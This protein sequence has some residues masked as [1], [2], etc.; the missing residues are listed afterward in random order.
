MSREVP[1][2]FNEGVALMVDYR[3]PGNGLDN[4]YQ[5][6]L[7]KWQQSSLEGQ[8]AVSLQELESVESFYRGDAFWINLAYLRSGLE[9]SGWLEK[10]KQPGL[11]QFTQALQHEISFEE[12]WRMTN[13]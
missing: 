9:V 5:N 10:V 8:I 4:T 11:L 13:E 12:A 6:Y 7:R 3:Y 2:W 1:Q